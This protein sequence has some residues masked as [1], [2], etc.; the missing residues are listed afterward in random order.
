MVV[1]P[2][3]GLNSTSLISR[4]L[5][6]GNPIPSLL[7]RLGFPIVSE[8]IPGI[9]HSLR[10]SGVSCRVDGGKTHWDYSLVRLKSG[11][12]VQQSSGCPVWMRMGKLLT[13]P[14]GG[15]NGGSLIVMP[16]RLSAWKAPKVMVVGLI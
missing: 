10:A 3:P 7:L 8:L 2:G 16:G 15:R 13:V 6:H 9:Q 4:L 1:S 12:M 5:R 11:S 14:M